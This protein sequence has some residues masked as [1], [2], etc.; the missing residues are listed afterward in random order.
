MRL[1]LVSA[2]TTCCASSSP[3]CRS[4]FTG[5]DQRLLRVV[6]NRVAPAIERA[7]LVETVRASQERL[8]VLSRRLVE[9]QEVERGEIARELHDEVGQLLTGL[10]LMIDDGEQPDA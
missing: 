5:E 3:D 4:P 1:F 2:W 8:E 10:G 9:I 7:R 6:A